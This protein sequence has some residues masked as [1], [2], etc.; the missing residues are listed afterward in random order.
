MTSP[1][2]GRIGTVLD[3]VA[4]LTPISPSHVAT[5]GQGKTL[6][7]DIEHQMLRMR[8]EAGSYI[9]VAKLNLRN[10]SS[11]LAVVASASLVVGQTR[12]DNANIVFPEGGTGSLALPFIVGVRITGP[13]E[14][15]LMGKTFTPESVVEVN[16]AVIAAVLCEH[17]SIT[18]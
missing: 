6:P 5:G 14:V 7:L 4:G 15:Q 16:N 10:L 9:I 1:F 18:T 2:F 3:R 17:L 12:D 13:T 8:L 11:Q